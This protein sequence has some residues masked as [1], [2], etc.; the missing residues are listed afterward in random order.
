MRETHRFSAFFAWNF[1]HR[2]LAAAAIRAWPSVPHLAALLLGTLGCKCPFSFVRT[3]RTPA[4][5]G[6]RQR[7]SSPRFEAPV[8][9]GSRSLVAS[10]L[11]PLMRD[12]LDAGIAAGIFGVAQCLR[13][14]PQGSLS[15]CRLRSGFRHRIEGNSTAHRL[16]NS[17]THEAH[18]T[19]TLHP[20]RAHGWRCSD[21]LFCCSK[22]R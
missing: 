19:G 11:L 13:E 4:T 12:D 1:A 10:V 15:V 14:A 6:S 8:V 22:R 17:Y 2:A 16:C 7:D 21:R 18:R 9:P 3:R 5:T 20:R